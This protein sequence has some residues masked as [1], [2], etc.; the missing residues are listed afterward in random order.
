MAEIRCKSCGNWFKGDTYQDFC[1]DCD[2]KIWQEQ[3]KVSEEVE[4]ILTE[5]T[6]WISR[7]NAD[8]KISEVKKVVRQGLSKEMTNYTDRRYCIRC[9]RCGE[10]ID[11]NASEDYTPDLCSSCRDK[12]G[13]EREQQRQA[14]EEIDEIKR[15]YDS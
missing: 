15:R 11:D 9:P 2:R 8:E 3:K 14:E 1:E 7:D 13:D 6:P 5:H 10:V 12:V 4:N